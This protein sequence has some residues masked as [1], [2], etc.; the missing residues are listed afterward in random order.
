[1]TTGIRKLIQFLIT[2]LVCSFS[3]KDYIQ[4]TYYTLMYV[5]V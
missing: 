5:P 4:C 3:Y 2:A 1:M